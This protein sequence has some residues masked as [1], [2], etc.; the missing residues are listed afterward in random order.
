MPTPPGGHKHR[1]R[2][3]VR[4]VAAAGGPEGD[5]VDQAAPTAVRLFQRPFEAI[6][7]RASDVGIGDRRIGGPEGGRSRTRR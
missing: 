3:I 1:L 4:V 5:R 7:E 2:H 6:S